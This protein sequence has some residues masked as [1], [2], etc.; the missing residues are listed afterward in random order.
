MP[1]SVSGSPLERWVTTWREAESAL[2]D[3]KR[4]EL[5]LVRTPDAIATLAA[6]FDHA[7]RHYNP[8]DTS[9][10]VEQQRYFQRLVP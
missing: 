9:G 10:L 4:R 5:V 7:V 6:A 8:P 2:A 1:E 3:E